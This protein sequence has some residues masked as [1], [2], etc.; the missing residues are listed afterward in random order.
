MLITYWFLNI[1]TLL[2]RKI[3]LKQEWIS[4]KKTVSRSELWAT[5]CSFD[6][7]IFNIKSTKDK[8]YIY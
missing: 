1:F 4:N 8:L 5:I 2:S 7:P 6:T 3:R